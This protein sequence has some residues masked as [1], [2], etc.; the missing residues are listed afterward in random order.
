MGGTCRR[1]FMHRMDYNFTECSRFGKGKPITKGGSLLQRP[2]RFAILRHTA[3][4]SQD[5]LVAPFCR[6]SHFVLRK[7][8]LRV[9]VPPCLKIGQLNRSPRRAEFCSITEFTWR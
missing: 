6:Q 3:C 4:H 8:K 5:P 2:L 9:T 1:E 7:D